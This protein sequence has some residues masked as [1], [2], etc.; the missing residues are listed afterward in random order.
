MSTVRHSVDLLLHVAK[1]FGPPPKKKKRP[2]DCC[3]SNGKAFKN[4]L[5]IVGRVGSVLMFCLF[6]NV[7]AAFVAVQCINFA[8]PPDPQP[9]DRPPAPL[10]TNPRHN[11]PV[12]N[13]SLV[14]SH[15]PSAASPF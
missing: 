14:K 6:E 1:D 15:L 13:H 7:A 2:F 12:L 3:V 10:S 5:T 8:Q 11:Q 9:R 4:S